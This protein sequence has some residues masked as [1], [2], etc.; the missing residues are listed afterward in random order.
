VN[1]IV[2]SAANEDILRQFEYYFVEQD[3]ETVAYRFLAAVQSA[4]IEICRAP[5]IGSPKQLSSIKLKGL[6]SWPVKGFAQIRVYYLTSKSTVR[7]LRVLHGKR[8]ID[9]ILEKQ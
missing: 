2:R 4:I 7:I 1:F 8:D 9:S 3:A 5:H 6:R